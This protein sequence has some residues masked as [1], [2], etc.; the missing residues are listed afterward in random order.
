M[1]DEVTTNPS[2]TQVHSSISRILI[3]LEKY[4][5]LIRE[6]KDVLLTEDDE[7]NT[8]DESLNSSNSN[9]WFEGMKLDMDSMY[10]N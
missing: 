1:I 8:Y 5:F 4:V 6:Q 3:V 10:A 7:P 9:K 2:K